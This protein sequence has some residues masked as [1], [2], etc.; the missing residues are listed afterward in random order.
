MT[1][2]FAICLFIFLC[3]V[4]GG[5]G[6]VVVVVICSLVEKLLKKWGLW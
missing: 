5:L 1:D 4:A 6:V 2:I 3:V